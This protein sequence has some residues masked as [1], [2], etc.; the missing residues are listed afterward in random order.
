MTTRNLPSTSL[1]MLYDAPPGFTPLDPNKPI[2]IY[3]RHLSHWRQEGATYATTFHTL[4]ALPQHCLR[5]LK[6]LRADWE[7][8]HPEQ[9][10]DEAWLSYAQQFSR[11]ANA[12]LDEGHDERYHCAAY[13][14]M[15]NHCHLIIRPFAGQDLETLL[16]GIKGAAA[17]GV[18]KQLGQ[19]G[20]SLWQQESYDRIIRDSKHLRHALDYLLDNPGK[21]GLGEAFGWRCHVADDWLDAGWG[22]EYF[23]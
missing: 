23:T 3:R 15:P 14:I 1:H 7:Q 5:E 6:Q 16:K 20:D 11:R 22:S 17:R 18:N 9:R 19:S 4:D 21:A 12:W 8:R 10:S 2:T 13:A